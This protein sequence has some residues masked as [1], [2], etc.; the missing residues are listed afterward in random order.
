MFGFGKSKNSK[1]LDALK[2]QGIGGQS[3][4]YKIFI[5]AL[6]V[7]DGKIRKIELTYFSL[8][9]LTYVFLR[10]YGGSEKGKIIDE[11]A[12]SIIKSS[13]PN[14]GETISES[15]AIAEY[16]RRYQEYDVLLRSLFSK[17]HVDPSTTLLMHFNEKV[18][19]G[20]AKGAMLQIAV[21]SSLIHQYV[22]DNIDFVKQKL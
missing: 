8:S 4:M 20:S 22:V 11:T 16:Q 9:V 10:L 13:I 21:A 5:K 15:R 6:N 12:I 1:V 2:S 7:P 19:N 18:V 17:N 14:C 3:V